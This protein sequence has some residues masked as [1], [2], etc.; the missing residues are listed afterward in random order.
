MIQ[1]IQT[2][3]LLIVAALNLAVVFLPLAVIQ[4]GKTFY[5]FS[6]SGMSMFEPLHELVYL[7]WGLMA[8]SAH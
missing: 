8:L 2:V 6:A 4:S 7:T 1:R 3:Y 5:I